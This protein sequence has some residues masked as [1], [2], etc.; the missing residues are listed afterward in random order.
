MA[1]EMIKIIN[2]KIARIKKGITQKELA[3]IAGVSSERDIS[4]Y[5]KGD[6]TPPL[7]RL[8]KMADYLGVTLDYLVGRE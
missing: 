8:C 2:L 6:V 4:R 5:E 3:K 7:H 1:K